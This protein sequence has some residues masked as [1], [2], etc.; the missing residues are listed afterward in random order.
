MTGYSTS[1]TS[2]TDAEF[3]IVPLRRTELAACARLERTL[4]RQDDP[5]SER[6]FAS[7]LAAGYR[8]FGAHGR[9]GELIGYA[10][11]GV[12]GRE[13]D[14]EASVHTIG[15]DPTWQGRGV[16]KALLGVLLA[17]A[18]ELGA[19]VFLEVRTDNR[20]AIGLYEAH[21]FTMLGLR[22]G[23]YPASGADAFTMVRPASTVGGG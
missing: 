19:P 4:Y 17:I 23:Y 8:Y 2:S 21:G 9:D 18:D 1:T 11:L 14:Y 6:V 15:V 22:R 3:S 10:G 7:E 16:G 5:W 13:P 20:V 12:F